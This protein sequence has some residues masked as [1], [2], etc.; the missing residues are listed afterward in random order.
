ML[1]QE[2][3]LMFDIMYPVGIVFGTRF[4]AFPGVA[5]LTFTTT[6]SNEKFERMKAVLPRV[7]HSFYKCISEKP[8]VL[9]WDGALGALWV[10]WSRLKGPE[11]GEHPP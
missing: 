7:C 5:W 9:R 8:D 2:D 1:A 11:F 10:D 3:F 6:L 4:R